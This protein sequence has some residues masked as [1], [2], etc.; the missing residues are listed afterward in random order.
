MNCTT[1]NDKFMT[2]VFILQT[3][4]WQTLEYTFIVIIFIYC[5]VFKL[6]NDAMRRC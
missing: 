5:N 6:N 4:Q 2:F 3:R 1:K